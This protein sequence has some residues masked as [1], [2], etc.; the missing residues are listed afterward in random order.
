VV[1]SGPSI[2]ICDLVNKYQMI[3][4]KRTQVI[5]PWYGWNI[6]DLALNNQHSLTY[7]ITISGALH[8]HFHCEIYCYFIQHYWLKVYQWLADGE[9]IIWRGLETSVIHTFTFFSISHESMFTMT[10]INTLFVTTCSIFIARE[11]SW[12]KCSIWLT[13]TWH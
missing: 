6:A 7:R 10:A 11:R 9:Y 12:L 2:Y 8:P 3:C 13:L 4:L 1:K 5:E